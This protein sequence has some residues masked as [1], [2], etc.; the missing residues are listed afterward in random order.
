MPSK[1][2]ATINAKVHYLALG[3]VLLGAFLFSA[4]GI[5]IKM[6]YPF[7]IS[8]DEL[9]FWR[10]IFAL[11]FFVLIWLFSLGR[12]K[13]SLHVRDYW[14][15]PLLGFM[16]Y[17]FASWL[18]F[19]GLQYVSAGMERMLI[20]LY[21]TFVLLLGFL[22]SKKKIS[23]QAWLSLG[24]AYAGIG[25]FYSGDLDVHGSM[26]LIGAMYCIGSALLFALFLHLGE[27]LVKRLGSLWYTS[28]CM[29]F[30][31]IGTSLHQLFLH[32]LPSVQHPWALWLLALC[33]GTMGTVV[34]SLCLYWGISKIGAARASITAM[35]GP[36]STLGISW[37]FLGETIGLEESIGTVLI[38]L[39]VA[40]L[41]HKPRPK[42]E[43]SHQA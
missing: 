11:P 18:D 41:S 24:F 32:G 26:G 43:L 38:L 7:G 8:A 10:Q 20:Y 42:D 23:L 12:A 14:K 9:Q 17:Y 4:K 28:T 33:I 22:F 1:K 36:V 21:P 16:G 6:A 37:L 34:P 15:L 31:T 3:S 25:F 39:G 27:P 35:V 5:M 30:A 19:L 13:Q 29:I 2:D 40:G